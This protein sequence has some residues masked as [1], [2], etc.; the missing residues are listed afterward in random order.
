[1]TVRIQRNIT[2]YAVM[3]AFILGLFCMVIH[4]EEIRPVF[5]LSFE[6]GL[7][8]DHDNKVKGDWFGKEAPR[9]SEYGL[10]GKALLVGYE[11]GLEA[12]FKMPESATKTGTILFWSKGDKNWDLYG[13]PNSGATSSQFF[14]GWGPKGWSSIYKWTYDTA[15]IKLMTGTGSSATHQLFYP[16][17]DAME[18]TQLGLTYENDHVRLYLNGNLVQEDKNFPFELTSFAIGGNK[19]PDGCER[20]LDELVIYDKALSASDIKKIY[21][22]D[23]GLC[24]KPLATIPLL[25]TAP[26]VDGTIAAAEWEGAAQVRGLIRFSTGERAE[27]ETSV[28]LGYSGK[29]LYVAMHGDLTEIARTRPEQVAMD[30]FLYNTRT[31]HDQDVD[32][33]DAFEIVMAPRFWNSEDST[34]YRMLANSAG[35]S[36]DYYSSPTDGLN[37]AWNPDWKT[38]SKVDPQGWDFEA[39]IPLDSFGETNWKEGDE[40]GLQIVRIW[41]KLKDQWDVW[42]CGTRMLDGHQR[43]MRMFNVS[44]H[45]GDMFGVLR[46]G[47]VN[48]PVVRVISTGA[49]EQKQIDWKAELRNPSDKAVRLRVSLLS[50]TPEVKVE[51]TVEIPAHGIR[52]F[53]HQAKLAN[54]STSEIAF[55]VYD[56][57][58]KILFHR[59]CLPFH[60]QQTF[61]VLV[62]R[63]PSYERFLVECDL[64]L[65]SSVPLNELAL[66]FSIGKADSAPIWVK[67]DVK[68]SGYKNTFED[69]TEA[70]PVGDYALTVNVRR[71]D[72]VLSRSEHHFPKKPMPEWW[73]NAYGRGSKVPTPFTSMEVDRVKDTISVWGRD[74]SYGGNLFPSQINT[75]GNAILSKPVALVLTEADG[76]EMRIEKADTVKWELVSPKRVEFIR[77][78]TVR[79]IMIS[80]KGWAEYDGLNWYD[81]EI[82]APK[83]SLPVSVRLDIPYAPPFSKLANLYD[84]SMNESGRV[85]FEKGMFSMRP[86]WLGNPDGGLQWIAEHTNGWRLP[87]QKEAMQIMPDGSGAVLRINLAPQP[88][89]LN[90]PLQA[91]FGFN[92]TPV[93]PPYP[94]YRLINRNDH[95]V[96]FTGGSWSYKQRF[97]PVGL[98]RQQ[99]FGEAKDNFRTERDSTARYVSSGVY[100]TSN[101]MHPENDDYRYWGDEWSSNPNFVYV[102]DPSITDFSQRGDVAVCQACPSW[103]DFTV[104]NYAKLFEESSCRGIYADDAPAFCSNLHH[105]HSSPRNTMLGYREIVRRIYETLREKY[106]DQT[107]SI[108]HMSGQ[109]NMAFDAFFDVYATGENFSSKITNAQPHYAFLFPVDTFL[110]ESRGH[111]WGPTCWFLTQLQNV[112]DPFK[113]KYGKEKEKWYPPW[114]AF[115]ND[116]EEYIQGLVLLT[117]STLWPGWSPEEPVKRMRDAL[118]KVDFNMGY[119]FIGFWRQTITKDMPQN[120]YASFYVDKLRNRVLLV[121]VNNSDSHAPVR[122]KLDWKQLGLNPATVQ[123]E[124]LAHSYLGEKNWARTEGDALLF[125]CGPRNYRLIYLSCETSK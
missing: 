16:R 75:Q 42:G 26:V 40:W 51:E 29:M 71:G 121:Y 48:S 18:W 116:S 54:F 99:Y 103:Q 120:A 25:S 111:N 35:I 4:A 119:D 96:A 19:G 65:F 110:T 102:R 115:V 124:N 6:K 47:G 15:G 56:E 92:A 113:Q 93:R 106:P 32:A 81:V 122:L 91:S 83:D 60:I 41:K 7:A 112:R 31:Q 97:S 80:V 123:A 10:K 33:D 94:Q 12:K 62:R 69:S 64:G 59:T 117:D 90:I 21:R 72:Q 86:V 58:G 9:F 38:A 50:D 28:L 95:P 30:G 98:G 34:E 22:R 8:P 89:S 66:D 109:R 61:G 125:S 46:F 63:Y 5:R 14:K 76:K 44:P 36:Y 79:N 55:E 68:P 85:P 100:Y 2:G 74:Y 45:R 105:E 101:G 20:L 73:K 37:L 23:L 84:Y 24:N 78:A 49:L 82:S 118:R 53:A 17:F 114:A 70:I 11:N 3:L 104:W 52:A 77:R 57:T 108:H 88:T 107:Y 67:K 13:G 27:D 43:T 39:A 1:M 87:Q